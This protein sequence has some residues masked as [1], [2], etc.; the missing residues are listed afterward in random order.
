[1]GPN[2]R[3]HQILPDIAVDSG[4]LH[5]LW[6]DT[7]NQATWNI[8]LPIGDRADGSVENALDVYAVTKS[9]TS[10]PGSWS[11]AVPVTDETTNP[12]YDQFDNR[13]TP[14]AGDYLWISASGGNTYGVWTDW[15]KT[16]PG[17]DPRIPESYPAGGEVHQF[18]AHVLEVAGYPFCRQPVDIGRQDHARDRRQVAHRDQ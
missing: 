10:G 15:R 8:Q 11:S 17:T 5:A 4:T 9:A 6:W 7:R 12:N 14:F 2:E 16:V 1:M 18:G 3:G 13:Q